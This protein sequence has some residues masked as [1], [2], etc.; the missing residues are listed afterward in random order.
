MPANTSNP[1]MRP[2]IPP[3]PI[4]PVLVV[5]TPLFSAI[6][7]AGIPVVV[8][9]VF[10][11]LARD[12]VS[13]RT[14]AAVVAAAAGTTLP[15]AAAAA[16]DVE[17]VDDAA[18]VLLVDE[19]T[20]AAV[21]EGDATGATEEDDRTTTGV[22]EVGVATTAGDIVVAAGLV[23]TAAALVVAASGIVIVGIAFAMEETA[24]TFPGF[25]TAAAAGV[26]REAGLT[27]CP[28]AARKDD[29]SAPA[30]VIVL[31]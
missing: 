30:S 10:R 1:M 17:D 4:E 2:A 7:A 3:P 16:A 8:V 27:V 5:P 18:L 9:D 29:S 31:V 26:E 14:G 13:A 11:R 12:V 15:P 20:A 6:C 19:T 21:D 23:A 22:D 25:A 24:A 28:P